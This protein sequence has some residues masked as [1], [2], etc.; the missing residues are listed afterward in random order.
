MSCIH[1]TDVY[2]TH[3]SVTKQRS[4]FDQVNALSYISLVHKHARGVELR[5]TEKQLKVVGGQNRT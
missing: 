2:K 4:L 3:I 5:F 1:H